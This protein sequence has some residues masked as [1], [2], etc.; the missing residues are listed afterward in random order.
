MAENQKE[1][2]FMNFLQ[3]NDFNHFRPNIKMMKNE[4]FGRNKN[5]TKKK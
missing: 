4:K 1:I 3:M 5:G 2:F